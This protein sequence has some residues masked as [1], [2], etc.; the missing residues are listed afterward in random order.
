MLK[1]RPPSA[2]IGKDVRLR[3]PASSPCQQSFKST[4]GTELPLESRASLCRGTSGPDQI[5]AKELF[6]ET[7]QL[8]A[9][10]CIRL[11]TVFVLCGLRPRRQP[12]SQTAAESSASNKLG[13]D[14][15]EGDDQKRREQDARK[16]RMIIASTS[17]L[18][19]SVR[20]LFQATKDDLEVYAKAYIAK[21]RISLHA[22]GDVSLHPTVENL[23]DA[24][25]TALLHLRARATYRLYPVLLTLESND[26]EH[27][28]RG[29]GGTT[30]DAALGEHECHSDDLWNWVL[31]MPGKLKQV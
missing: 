6:D 13:R 11:D 26:H 10:D 23:A 7:A 18:L 4:S 24:I 5:G 30:G 9:L 25:Q 1:R 15:N 14:E 31:A 19:E 28:G 12:P 29:E 16:L 22:E 2:P 8:A 20:I 3:S 27:R 21:R 17:N